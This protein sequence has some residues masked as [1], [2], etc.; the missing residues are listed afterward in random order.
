MKISISLRHAGLHVAQRV[1]GLGLVAALASCGGSGSSDN[2]MVAPVATNMPPASA[3]AS[4]DGFIAFMKT[5]VATQDNTGA[6][7]DVSAFIAPKSDTA[8]PDL[9]I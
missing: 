7:L 1:A 2:G 4:V 6:G 3:A 9:T 5:L 8:T